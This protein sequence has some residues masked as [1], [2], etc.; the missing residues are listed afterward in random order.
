MASELH[1]GAYSISTDKSR[2][3]LS[4]VHGF[5]SNSYWSP[6]VPLEIVKS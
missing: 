2:I 1:N 5:L 3:D 4:V 6:G